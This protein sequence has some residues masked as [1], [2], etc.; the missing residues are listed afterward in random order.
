SL[1]RRR[2]TANQGSKPKT[3]TVSDSLIQASSDLQ[4]LYHAME[5]FLVALG[6][7]VTKK[8]TQD[9][10][11]FRRIK[12]FACIEVRPQKKTLVVYLKVDVT[13]TE[14]EKDF[15][16]DVRSIGHWGTGDLEVTLTSLQD[17]E[18]AKSLLTTSYEN[19]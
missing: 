1:E 19:S 9:Y 7:D 12:N 16:R 17:L 6:D 2:W 4:D 15:T 3:K 11:A 8:I 13:S 14:L 10:I 18:R 5:N